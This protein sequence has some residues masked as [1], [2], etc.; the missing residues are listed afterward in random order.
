MG[1]FPCLLNAKIA[2]AVC[3]LAARPES[4]EYMSMEGYLASL[5]ANFA[6]LQLVHSFNSHSFSYRLLPSTPFLFLFLSEIT[7]SWSPP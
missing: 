3:A 6:R 5:S 2:Y 7:Q 1:N 4:S